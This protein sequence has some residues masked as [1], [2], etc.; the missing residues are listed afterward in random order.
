MKCRHFPLL[1]IKRLSMKLGGEPGIGPT[2]MK[3]KTEIQAADGTSGGLFLGALT[4][5]WTQVSSRQVSVREF[6][7]NG[8]TELSSF[9]SVSLWKTR[10]KNKQQRNNEQRVWREEKEIQLALKFIQLNKEISSITLQPT[11]P[12][13]FIQRYSCTWVFTAHL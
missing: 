6:S 1:D 2:S 11:R 10:N 3:E 5:P 4:S 13:I 8:N 12:V 7:S 9:K